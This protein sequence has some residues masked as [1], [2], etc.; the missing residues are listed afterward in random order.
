MTT[1]WASDLGTSIYGGAKI[2]KNFSKDEAWLAERYIEAYEAI[3]KH[4]DKDDGVELPI[5]FE[6]G[7]RPLPDD[8][9]GARWAAT[10]M[11]M[12]MGNLLAWRL[13]QE[14]REKATDHDQRVIAQL[15]D[16]YLDDDAA[17][18]GAPNPPRPAEEVRRGL[19]RR[20]EG[21]GHGRGDP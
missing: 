20:H 14:K 7:G 10:S 2:A 1:D 17:G 12:G 18:W 11:L 8:P 9:R 5:L 19:L 3:R 6:P 13:C 21:R 15:A 16:K 4:G